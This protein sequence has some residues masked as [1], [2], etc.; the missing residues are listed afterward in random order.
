MRRFNFGSAVWASIVAT[1]VMTIVM[2]FFGTDLMNM[3]GMTAGKTG[4]MA[5]IFG[6]VIHFGVGIIFGLVYAL[7]FEPILRGLPGFLAG[8]LYSLLPFFVAMFFMNPFIQTIKTTFGNK[9]ASAVVENSNN[10]KHNYERNGSYNH[11]D[12]TSTPSANPE[13]HTPK[14]AS[15]PKSGWLFSLIAHLVYGVFLGWIY[16]PRISQD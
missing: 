8:A 1:V 9:P 13:K 5:Y 3:L 10:Q 2:W 12:Y 14:P 11:S 6:G 7:I 15:A 16:R 4:T